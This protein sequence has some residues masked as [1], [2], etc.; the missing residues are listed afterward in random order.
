M[1]AWC[2]ETFQDRVRLGLRI[3]R[4]LYHGQSPYQTIDIVDTEPY[5]VT[6]LLDR[7]YMTSVGDE[8]HYHELLVHPALTSAPAIKRVLV[9]GGGDGGTVREV[10][11]YREVQHVTMCEIDA[12]VTDACKQHLGALNVP[13]DDPRLELRFGDGVAYLRDHTGEPFDVILIDGSDPVGPAEGLIHGSF[14]QSCKRRLAPEGVLALQSE[15]PHLMREDF[16]RIVH[17][18]R[19]VFPRVHPY[20]G[21]VPIYPSGAWSWTFASEQIDPLYPREDRLAQI[22]QGCRYYNR[23]IHRAAFVQPNDIRAALR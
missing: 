12:M 23:D 2:D 8:Y 9:I 18:L 13:W 22:E 4:T 20:F 21:P 10:L 19:G 11:R 14:Y 7:A 1:G 17:S 16:L 3:T 5:G 6:L 15:A